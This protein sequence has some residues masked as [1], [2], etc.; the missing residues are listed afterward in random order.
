[1]KC[2][3]VAAPMPPNLLQQPKRFGRNSYRTRR[4]QDLLLGLEDPTLRDWDE[5]LAMQ[6]GWIGECTGFAFSWPLYADDDAGS[7]PTS[8][9][10]PIW[11]EH[12]ELLAGVAFVAVSPDHLL[13]GPSPGKSGSKSARG[14]PVMWAGN[15]VS[16]RRVPVLVSDKFEYPR[17]T[18]SHLG[19][20]PTFSLLCSH[21][22][23]HS[24]LGVCKWWF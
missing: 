14:R 5:V 2:H 23:S 4:V 10:L 22:V 9:F 8:D 24:F 7:S 3:L 18:Q 15:P 20:A 1:M 6:R 17:S 16:G 19:E 12:P 21:I 11:T 13:A